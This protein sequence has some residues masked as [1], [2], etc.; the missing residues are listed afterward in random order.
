MTEAE[1]R[2]VLKDFGYFW[3]SIWRSDYDEKPEI[4]LEGSFGIQELRALALLMER[5]SKDEL[6]IF[7]TNAYQ[8]EPDLFAG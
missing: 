6:Y 5:L 3:W 8:S 2:A 7:L 4:S 1:A